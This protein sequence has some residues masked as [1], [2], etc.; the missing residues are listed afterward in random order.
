M[1]DLLSVK[2]G[3]PLKGGPGKREE[4]TSPKEK[5]H[6][7]S[8]LVAMSPESTVANVSKKKRGRKRK[9]SGLERIT[10]DIES[11]VMALVRVVAQNAGLTQGEFFQKASVLYINELEKLN[12]PRIYEH[13]K[14]P[15]IDQDANT[16]VNADGV[17][18]P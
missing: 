7:N 5:S 8:G 6:Q 12:G 9:R 17:A 13:I 11:E 2:K 16:E 15:S 1:T 14:L 18:R 4:S 10:H 3:S